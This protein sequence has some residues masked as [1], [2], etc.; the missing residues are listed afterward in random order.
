[1]VESGQDL[2]NTLEDG[3]GSGLGRRGWKRPVSGWRAVRRRTWVLITAGAVVAVGGVTAGLLAA[4]G[5][6]VPSVLATVDGALAKSSA[7]NYSFTLDST[8]RLR[9]QVMS[10]DMVSGVID[11]GRELGKERLAIIVGR[12]PGLVPIRFIAGY[13]YTWVP[14][15]GGFGKPWDKATAPAAGMNGIPGT[16]GFVSDQPVSPGELSGLLQPGAAVRFAG[17]AS[18]PGWTGSRYTFAA[19]LSGGQGSVSGNVYVD[20][21]GRV[22]RTVTVT[23]Q[24]GVI[25]DR[26]LAFGDF[27]APM[28]VAA[29]PAVQV[30]YT[31]TPYLG[32]YF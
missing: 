31:R 8:V 6:G 24:D 13:V 17:P 14:A 15:G 20:R 19:S 25:T 5:N 2:R 27:G 7:E 10:S 3:V 11:P 22:R 9:G 32:F 16:Y 1:M 12:H 18:G 26:D 29:P 23:T 21:Q 30:K 28:Q 4:S